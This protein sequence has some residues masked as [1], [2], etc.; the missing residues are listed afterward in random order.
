MPA[1]NGAVA[2]RYDVV[3]AGAGPVGLVAASILGMFGIRTLVAEKSVQMYT[4]PR[5]VGIDDEAMRAL[6]YIGIMP[7]QA[8]DMMFAPTIEYLSG[9]GYVRFQP[10]SEPQELGHP[11]LATFL[12][13]VL[14]TALRARLRD[15]PHVDFVQGLELVGYHDGSEITASLRRADG[16]PCHVGAQY[17]LGC[18]GA[19]SAVRRQAGIELL[20]ETQEEKWLVVDARDGDAVRDAIA[21]SRVA[22]HDDPMVTITLP[23]GLR[24]FEC[25]LP[26]DA[27]RMAEVDDAV[28]RRML[29]PF[30]GDTPVEVIRMSV[31]ERYFRTA[32]RLRDGRA[33]IL[34]DAAHLVPPYGGQGLCSGIRD[35]FNLA[36]KVAFV[37]KGELGSAVLSTYET[38][39]KGH[40]AATIEFVK[41]VARW[42]EGPIEPGASPVVSDET[43]V[44]RRKVKP[45]PVFDDGFFQKSMGG[46][47]MFPQ[48][49]MRDLQTGHPLLLDD[50][51]GTGFAV[52]RSEECRTDAASW[53]AWLGRRGA[54]IDVCGAGAPAARREGRSIEDVGGEV[55]R[56]MRAT[57]ATFVLLRPDRFVFAAG[58]D[59][60]AP[61]ARGA[62]ASW[63]GAA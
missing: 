53:K 20:G 11:F 48:P 10:P 55:G 16:A 39:R 8:A 41:G 42:I 29:R 6:Q 28:A 34:G 23:R 5:A 3:V 24:R 37:V 38:E 60:D 17:L 26:P 7:A 27:A 25:R 18:D 2:G 43:L 59:A 33:F 58:A 51:L 22:V 52:L 4:Y 54:V 19:K 30:V 63:T 14:E 12:Q 15:F 13:P 45:S 57:G 44:G 61:A 56:W 40:M 47:A 46:G 62:F 9:S 1:E 50:A 36:W 35:A 49:P 32:A 21:A 31:Y